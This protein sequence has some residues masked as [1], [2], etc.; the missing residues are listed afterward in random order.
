MARPLWLLPL[1]ALTPSA[2]AAWELNMPIG[3]TDQSQAIY[4]LHMLI[5]WICVV[6]SVIVYGIMAYALI[7]YRRSVRKEAAQFSHNTKLEILWTAL[8]ALVLV[9]LAI[10]STK[11]LIDIYDQSPGE[12][13][14]KVV[15]YQWKWGY[16]YLEEGFSFLSNISTSQDEIYGRTAKGEFYLLEVDKPIYIPVGKRVRFLITA[17]DVLHAFWVPEFGIKQDAIPGYFNIAQATV[18]TPGVYRGVCAELCGLNHGFMPITVVAVEEPEYRLWVEERK[19]EF[20]EIKAASGR[21]WQESELLERGEQAYARNC[22]VCHQ[23]DGRGVAGAFPA[24]AGSPIVLGDKAAQT[25]ILLRGV[26][27]TAMQAFGDILSATD[28]AA[29]LTYSRTA[30][31]NGE[32]IA[33]DRLVQPAEVLRQKGN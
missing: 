24:L 11:T 22:A 13:N 10:P 29:V 12:V 14:I 32:K 6:I 5:F 20:L 31:G 27:G 4:G 3:V 8:A 9:V 15:G 16:E 21:D 23:L 26:S 25:R 30:W 2:Q 18:Q 17:K 19:A 7:A 1:V 28:L 33:T